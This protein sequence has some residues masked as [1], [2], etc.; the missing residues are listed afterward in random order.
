MDQPNQK[1]SEEST[2]RQV[3]PL[4]PL[5]DIIVFPFMN[6]PLFVGRERSIQALDQAMSAVFPQQSRMIQSEDFVEGPRAFAEKRK[7]RWQGR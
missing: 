7:P 1:P 4:L 2:E 6:V 3:V 5:R